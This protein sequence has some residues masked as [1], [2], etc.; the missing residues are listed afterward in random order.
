[1]GAGVTR[2]LFIELVDHCN[3]DV[4]LLGSSALELHNTVG[5]QGPRGGGGGRRYYILEDD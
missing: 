2:K 3:V 5:G 1:M 4:L